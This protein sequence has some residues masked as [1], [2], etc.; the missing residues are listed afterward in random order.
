MARVFKSYDQEDPVKNYCLA[1]SSPQ[2]PVQLKLIEE[3]MKHSRVSI[4]SYYIVTSRVVALSNFT[5]LLVV[6]D[7]GRSR[8]Y[9]HERLAD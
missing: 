6:Q 4:Y 9:Q 2:H 5:L 1:H 8:G 7:A 3:T